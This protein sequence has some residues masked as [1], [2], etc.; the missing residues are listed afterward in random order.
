[1]LIFDEIQE[2][3]PIITSLK[4]SK[5]DFRDMP[6]I[7]SGSMVRIKLKRQNKINR[8]QNSEGFFSQ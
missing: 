1:L 6:V 8:Q 2:A 7:A 3:L 4:Y 5:Q